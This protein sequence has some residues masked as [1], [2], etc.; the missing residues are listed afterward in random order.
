MYRTQ[1]RDTSVKAELAHI[2]LL[3]QKGPVK[4]I[5]QALVMSAEMVQLSRQAL[6]R[7]HPALS[8]DELKLLWI[9]LNYGKDLA[10]RVRQKWPKVDSNW[11]AP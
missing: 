9:E 11:Q 10:N 5:Q 8:E 7:I 3:R 4:R 1:S 2:D 6:R